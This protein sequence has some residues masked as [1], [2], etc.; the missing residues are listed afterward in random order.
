MMRKSLILLFAF[1]AL[2]LSICGASR[3]T[4]REQV[5]ETRKR[6]KEQIKNLVKDAKRKLADHAAGEK[7]LTEEE[8]AELE[9][10]VDLFQRKVESMEVDLEE[11][12][13]ERL[14]DRGI[15]QDKRRRERSSRSRSIETEL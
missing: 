8:K 4:T 9:R 6:R 5:L 7:I 12:E 14:V 1:A 10:N 2:C 3:D 13:I 15:E 11:W